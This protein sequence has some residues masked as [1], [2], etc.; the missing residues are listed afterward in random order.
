MENKVVSQAC[1]A[2]FA[3]QVMH[4]V[5]RVPGQPVQGHFHNPRCWESKKCIHYANK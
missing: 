4:L 2:S 5:L 3:M 1:E